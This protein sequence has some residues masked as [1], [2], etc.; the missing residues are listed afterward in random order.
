METVDDETSA[1]AIDFME[2]ANDEGTPWVVW[3]SGTRMHSRTHISDE[4]R[5]LAKEVVG[6]QV[7]EYTAVMLEHDANIGL[8]L[9]KLD[10]LG[11]ADT[12]LV[13]YS[14]DNGPHMNTW[15]DAGITPFW[16]EKNTNWE[17]AWRVPAMV[18]RPRHIPEDDHALMYVPAQTYVAN[19]L[20][21]FQEQSPR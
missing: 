13:F 2:H 8:F 6:K 14:T 4:N 9:D 15:P 11:I 18:R 1:A 16:G 3:W 5:A 20:E 19:F 17:G 12:A 7:Y 10:E 21:S